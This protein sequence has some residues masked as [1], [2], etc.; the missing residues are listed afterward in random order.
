MK[1]KFK[2]MKL[3]NFF[4]G[5]WFSLIGHPYLAMKYWNIEEDKMEGLN[6]TKGV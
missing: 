6:T 3:K 2:G 4:K 1:I 5:M